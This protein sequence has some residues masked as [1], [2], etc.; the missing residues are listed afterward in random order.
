MAHTIKVTVLVEQD[1]VMAPGFPI[2]RRIQVNELI[3]I[4]YQQADGAPY[5]V[6]PYAPIPNVAA[7][8]LSAD[9]NVSLKLNNLIAW[10][11]NAAGLFVM[12]DGVLNSGALT[13]AVLQSNPGDGSVTNITG[14]AGGT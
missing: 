12:I 1:G 7:L 5:V 6:V 8:I 4:N 10:Q 14:L 13:N 3:G 11:L 9:K 2:Q